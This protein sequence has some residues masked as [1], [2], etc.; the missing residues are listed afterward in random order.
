IR[1]KTNIIQYMEKIGRLDY[2]L[3]RCMLIKRYDMKRPVVGGETIECE[4]AA[5]IPLQ[6]EC[7]KMN[8]PYRPLNIDLK[9]KINILR[10][11]NMGGKTVV[12]KTIAFCQLLVQTGFYV[13]AERY[14]CP[15]FD[16]IRFT[17]E[18]ADSGMS[19]L[20]S[21]GLEMWRLRELIEKQKGKVLVFIDEFARTT[22]SD[23]A[24]ALMSSLIEYFRDRT[25]Y[26]AL[27]ST[28]IMDLPVS[29]G[30]DFFR[31]NGLDIERFRKHT[32][33]IDTSTLKDHIRLI[34][35]YM[36]YTVVRDKETRKITDAVNIAELLGVDRDIIEKA[37]EFF[38]E[39]E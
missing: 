14:S 16:S 15:V 6:A 3:A 13:R 29:G 34:N 28:H 8:L 33:N 37:A 18:Y 10:G 26:S 39:D 21:F 25:E 32:G 4:D 31:M 12:L 1:E 27:F 7:E 38:R 19:G 5:Y 20:S 17:G 23:E 35:S 9:K 2:V 30:V 36:D 22:N 11:S 24:R